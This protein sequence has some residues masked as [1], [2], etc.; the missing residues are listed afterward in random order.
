MLIIQLEHLTTSIDIYQCTPFV[1]VYY[2]K[3]HIPPIM[4]FLQEIANVTKRPDVKCF[5][6]LKLSFSVKK[7]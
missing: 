3:V 2:V 4:K 5:F 7:L 6:Q 1:F